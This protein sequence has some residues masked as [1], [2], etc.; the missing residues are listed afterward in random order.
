MNSKQSR[1]SPGFYN[2]LIF[3][4]FLCTTCSAYAQT[5]S[6]GAGASGTPPPPRL[7]R[8]DERTPAQQ[9]AESYEP[10]GVRLGG[11]L[12]FPA[13]EADEAYNDNVFAVSSG[14]GQ[15]GSFLQLIRPSAELRSTWSTHMLNAYARGNIGFYTAAPAQNFQDVSVGVDGRI[16][17][18]RDWNTY[19][20]FSFNRKHEDPGLPNTP[21]GQTDVT[22]YNQ[23]TGLVGYYQKVNRLSGRAEFGVDTYNYFNNGLGIAE[24]V[25]PNSDRNRVEFRE[26]LRFGYE[27]LDGYEIWARGSLNQRIYQTPVDALGFARGSS[28]WDVVGGITLNLGGLTTAEAFAGYLQQNYVNQ[29]TAPLQGPMFGFMANWNPQ[30]ELWIKPYVRR[31]VNEAA[32]AGDSGYLSTAMGFNTSYNLR[33]NVRWNALADYT[34]ADYQSFSGT[35]ARYDQYITLGTGVMYLPVSEFFVALS[36]Q[37]VYRTST[38]AGLDYG[39]NVIMLRLGGRL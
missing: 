33:P 29:G 9:Q 35:N 16:D 15:I 7:E 18:Q 36:Y 3:T 24:G 11:F 14:S 23:V 26:S 38:Q 12:L 13:L 19:G 4:L 1:V 8:P 27:F 30:K 37:Y 34:I 5:M 2:P 22:I 31:T 21:T 39:Q 28:G 25:V 20:G 10:K 32:Y 17:I 6:P